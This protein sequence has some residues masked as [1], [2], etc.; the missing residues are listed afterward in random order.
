[1]TMSKEQKFTCGMHYAME[2]MKMNDPIAE[3][4]WLFHKLPKEVQ[5]E[6]IIIFDI[7]FRFWIISMKLIKY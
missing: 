1:M 6:L 5:D 2:V 4:N 7:I 3:I